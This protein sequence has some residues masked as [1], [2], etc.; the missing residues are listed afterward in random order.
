M[1]QWLDLLAR[2]PWRRQDFVLAPG[3]DMAKVGPANP[4]PTVERPKVHPCSCRCRFAERMV[5]E[6][7]R[8]WAGWD[9]W[10]LLPRLVLP[11][12]PEHV[13]G[14][15]CQPGE[16]DGPVTPGRRDAF[17]LQPLEPVTPGRA[18]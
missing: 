13:C 6:R 11:L 3:P 18:L 10:P 12:P 17:T 2:V 5:L 1:N 14:A 7:E 4:L 9:V 8:R 15:H 16:S